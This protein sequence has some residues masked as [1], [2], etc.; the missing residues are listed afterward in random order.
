MFRVVRAGGVFLTLLIVGVS[1]T[2]KID[3]LIKL[4]S[5]TVDGVIIWLQMS[6]LV[7]LLSFGKSSEIEKKI[8]YLET[9]R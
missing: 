3:W 4:V 5:L 7:R 8:K 9:D 2:D 6:S 1:S